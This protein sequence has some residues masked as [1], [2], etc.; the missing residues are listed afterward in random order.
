MNGTDVIPLDPEAA[1][2]ADPAFAEAKRQEAA[3]VE[4]L[5]ALEAEQ[6]ALTTQLAEIAATAATRTQRQKM[7][8]AVSEI[9]FE[10]AATQHRLKLRERDVQRVQR[11]VA[12]DVG[13][14]IA[15]QAT[16]AGE[17]IETKLDDL[18]AE[19]GAL[20]GLNV[21]ARTAHDLVRAADSVLGEE[22]P[23]PPTVRHACGLGEGVWATLAALRE[24][25][26]EERQR[27]ERLRH[28]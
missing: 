25:V 19:F 1:L 7:R 17:L 28:R 18:L 13:L 3:E 23:A 2:A 21:M 20:E 8:G 11:V 6:Q 27:R 15:A 12:A 22:T 24:A 10:V 14:H 5:R 26:H 4:R 9:G 16:S